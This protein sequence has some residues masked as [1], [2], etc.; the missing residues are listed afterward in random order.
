M[1]NHKVTD[2]NRLSILYPQIINMWHKTLN[3]GLMPSDFSLGSNKRIY[4]QCLK[5]TSHP[6]YEC[7]INTMVSNFNRHGDKI[8]GCPYC[9][10]LKA[11][12]TNNLAITN[13]EIIEE[14]DNT[15]NNISPFEITHGSHKIVWWKCKNRHEYQSTPNRRSSGIGCPY[16]S[17][18]K[19][20]TDNSLQVLAPEVAKLWDTKKN[21]G[22]SPINFTSQ[23][24]IVV[25]F[26][27]S[28]DSSHPSFPS[29]I[30]SMVR[31]FK[32]NNNGCPYCSGLKVCLS[33]S[34]LTTHPE[35]TKFWDII[36]NK[37]L[38][39]S[40]VSHASQSKHWW[41][42]PKG[43]SWKAPS[44]NMI[45]GYKN[46]SSGCPH[47]SGR[48]VS[49]ENCLAI[50]YP[51]LINEWN[52]TKNGILTPNDITAFSAKKVWWVC[53]FCKNEW[54]ST[55]CN[56]T[57]GR[58]GCPECKK[59]KGEKEITKTLDELKI[60]FK[61]QHRIKECRDK[62]PLPFDFAI[63]KNNQ[64]VGLIEYQG[65][66][67]FIPV[68]YGGKCGKDRLK[69]QQFHDKIKEDYCKNKNISFL[70]IHYKDF[71]NIEKLL[72]EFLNSIKIKI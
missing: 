33:N 51:E 37:G 18:K 42:C 38:L 65:H 43:H 4:L 46:E 68:N 13:P 22:L 21:N 15:K 28:K 60:E 25:Y 55:V 39:P 30:Y 56:R 54:E 26:K 44:G 10:G 16:C 63:L 8:T 69:K 19:V 41:R 2:A 20:C 9:R 58:V 32:N 11:C 52:F 72:K 71:D 34:I 61:S 12:L 14:W 1:G 59:S 64:V 47:C 36:K 7:M 49:S 6:P 35:L 27:C 70:S 24:N 45:K 29:Q 62:R 53:K 50:S 66:F 57:K 67:H 17:G 5:D 31:S 23:S 3:N 48:L 40:E